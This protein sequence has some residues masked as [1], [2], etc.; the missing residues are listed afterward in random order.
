MNENFPEAYNGIGIIEDKLGNKKEALISFD[1]AKRIDP[2][3]YIYWYNSGCV[4]K[5]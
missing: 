3:N 4:K 2:E 1:N 5:S